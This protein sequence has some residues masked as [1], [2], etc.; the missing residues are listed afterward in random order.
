MEK[1]SKQKRKENFQHDQYYNVVCN[2]H[3]TITSVCLCCTVVV[4]YAIGKTPKW[5]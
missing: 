1:L 3:L 4:G 5:K 2:F